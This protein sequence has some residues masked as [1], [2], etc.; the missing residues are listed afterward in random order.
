MHINA[1]EASSS[2]EEEQMDTMTHSDNWLQHCKFSYS[3]FCHTNY[4]VVYVP[5][6]DMIYVHFVHTQVYHKHVSSS[7]KSVYT[8]YMSLGMHECS[9]LLSICCEEIYYRIVLEDMKYHAK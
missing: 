4:M 3:A 7:Y 8:M 1:D 6:Y 2:D 5:V 9:S